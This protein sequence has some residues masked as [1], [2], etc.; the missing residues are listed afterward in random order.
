[1][2]ILNERIGEIST[3]SY[4]L[5]KAECTK[6]TDPQ[7]H[8][9]A[10][11][12]VLSILIKIAPGIDIS[13]PP[14][15]QQ[16]PPDFRRPQHTRVLHQNPEAPT[17]RTPH[18]IRAFKRIQSSIS[19]PRLL[20]HSCV[21]PGPPYNQ[22]LPAFA[23]LPSQS[24]R[25]SIVHNVPEALSPNPKSPTPNLQSS[26]QKLNPEPPRTPD[27]NPH[28]L[29]HASNTSTFILTPFFTHSPLS[30]SKPPI[31]RMTRPNNRA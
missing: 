31:P 14:S 23:H 30:K 9:L 24:S 16:T 29:A 13:T 12:I 26:D 8:P 10:R 15:L 6:R 1:M 20:S 7:P 27:E 3:R 19:F 17:P 5:P 11:S 4:T 18:P 2:K 22:L 28:T 25:T 21:H